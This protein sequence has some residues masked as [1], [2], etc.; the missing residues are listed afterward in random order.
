MADG[1]R[2]D[3]VRR[4][5]CRHPR[6]TGRAPRRAAGSGK[7]ARHGRTDRGTARRASRRDRTGCRWRDRDG[8]R[9]LRRPAFGRH[10]LRPHRTAP[11]RDARRGRRR[12]LCAGARHPRRRQ[13]PPAA[14]L[15]RR[16]ARLFRRRPRL[17]GGSSHPRAR[18]RR[19]PPR[20][21]EAPGG[22]DLGR[23]GGGALPCPRPRRPGDARQPQAPRPGRHPPPARSRPGRRAT[24]SDAAAGGR[25]G[26]ERGAPAAR[27]LGPSRR[28]ARRARARPL[29]WRAGLPGHDR[30]IAGRTRP[31]I[32]S[33]MEPP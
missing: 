19:P 30:E 9:A 11:R 17:G 10:S 3:G 7:P 22:G 24:L 1:R 31:P 18:P 13:C 8:R 12:G 27:R 25:A 2:D 29:P 14:D 21:A 23:R 32:P 33:G 16:T 4:C 5:S 28:P 20:R 26:D 15:D 6:R